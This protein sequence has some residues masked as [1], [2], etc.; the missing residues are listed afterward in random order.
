[1]SN[2][3]QT[4]KEGDGRLMRHGGSRYTMRVVEV[5]VGK[6]TVGPRRREDFGDIAALATGIA[7]V[8]LL[9]P[10]VVDETGLLVCGERRL[11]AVKLLKWETVPVQLRSQ[12]T[13]AELRD[14]ELEENDNRKSLT[15]RE[16]A[17]RFESSKKL[18]E[19]AK[20]AAEVSPQSADKPSGGRPAQYGKPKPEVAADLGVSED[21]LVRA[22]QHV[23][24]AEQFPFMKGSQW[25]Q[26]DVLR[27]RE[28]L[29]GLPAP[30]REKVADVIACAKLMDPAMAVQIVENI[31]SKK[32]TERAEIYGLSKSKDPRDVSLALTKAAELPPMPDPRI[33]ILENAL[34][35]LGAAI[36][37]YPDDPLT[38]SL[39]S[40][41][42]ELRAAL[43]QV[44]AG[45]FNAYRDNQNRKGAIQ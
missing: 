33:G 12:L 41:R 34:R 17:R 19:N 27:V 37:P 21:T 18:V 25:K 38:P 24:T 10:L 30:E 32:P 16:R 26:S 28:R 23:A 15:E 45:S 39:V 3:G 29:E 13:E 1:V 5:P 44:R 35:Y 36:K 9:E 6:I 4:S 31:S 14:I 2:Y 20:R 43:A 40:I 8:G 11:R 22:E 7:R 42:T